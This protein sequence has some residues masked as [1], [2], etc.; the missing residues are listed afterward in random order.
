MRAR[1]AYP[2]QFESDYRTAVVGDSISVGSDFAVLVVDA[3]STDCD[4]LIPEEWL[5]VQFRISHGIEQ[6]DVA[7]KY[8]DVAGPANV[9]LGR[10]PSR[11]LYTVHY[12]GAILAHRP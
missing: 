7:T 12:L 4:L 6:F 3:F 5:T 9:E 10:R 11:E 1:S 2:K 8:A